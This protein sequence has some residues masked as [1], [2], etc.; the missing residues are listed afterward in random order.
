MFTKPLNRLTGQVCAARV[1]AIM[2]APMSAAKNPKPTTVEIDLDHSGQRLDN[3]LLTRLKGVPRSRIYRLVRRGE[4]RINKGRVAPGYRLQRGDLVRIPPVRTGVSGAASVPERPAWVDDILYEDDDLLVL[5]KPAGAAVHA[6]TGVAAGVIEILRHYRPDLRFLDLVHR[7]DRATSGCLLLAKRRS[8]LT[9]LHADLRQNSRKQHRIR[10]TYTALLAGRIPEA[11]TVTAALEKNQVQ[12]GERMVKV[13]GS[14]RYAHSRFLPQKHFAQATLVKIN[15]YTGRTHQARVHAAHLG[16][17]VAGDDKYG[18]KSFNAALRA[19]GLRRM[20]L[21]ASGLTFTHPATGAK[22][23][24][25][26]PLPDD[27]QA[28]LDNMRR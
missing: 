27:L 14:G 6:G 26:A 3:Y 16:H 7:L 15:L 20:F 24:V 2:R 28:V 12:S 19:L 22:V 9:A 25:T 5:N 10:K 23:E 17:P 18:D 1:F 11:K 4:V 8:A 13:S 21:H